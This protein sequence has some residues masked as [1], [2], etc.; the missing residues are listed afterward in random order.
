MSAVPWLVGGG[1]LAA[2]LWTRGNKSSSVSDQIVRPVAPAMLPGEWVWPVVKWNERQSSISDGVGSPRPGGLHRGVDIM[3]VRK[4]NDDVL[5]VIV[6]GLIVES[7]T[8]QHLIVQN[9]VYAGLCRSQFSDTGM[10]EQQS[11][12]QAKAAFTAT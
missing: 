7:G 5:G 2:F 8:H 4:A 11:P 10:V 3:F 9:G 1:T 6:D 12:G